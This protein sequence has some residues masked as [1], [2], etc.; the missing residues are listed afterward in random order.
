MCDVNSLKTD[1]LFTKVDR[2]SGA[3]YL[4]DVYWELTKDLYVNK[5]SK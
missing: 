2:L 3:V 5:V 4:L 1:G